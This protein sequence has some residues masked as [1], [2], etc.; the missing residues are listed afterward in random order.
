MSLAGA[1]G[2][3]KS[4]ERSPWRFFIPTSKDFLIVGWLVFWF[5]K[6]VLKEEAVTKK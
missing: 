3:S 4:P 6:R 1:P 2:P 5:S